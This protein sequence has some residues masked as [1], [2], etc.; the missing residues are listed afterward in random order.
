M[1]YLDEDVEDATTEAGTTTTTATTT[2]EPGG[3]SGGAIAGISVSVVLVVI[4]VLGLVIFL[5]IRSKK[6]KI[7]GR[8]N[9]AYLEQSQAEKLKAKGPYVLPL[10]QPERLI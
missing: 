3:L 4:L 5:Y 7:Q 1:D 8:Y 10:P 2:T 9:P 6:R